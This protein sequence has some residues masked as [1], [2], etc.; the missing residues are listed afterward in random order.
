MIKLLKTALPHYCVVSIKKY[1]I[2]EIPINTAFLK[3]RFLKNHTKAP[4]ISSF[5]HP[6]I[7]YIWGLYRNFQPYFGIEPK[8]FIKK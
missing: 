2:F 7:L 1:K 3:K 6:Q 5:S 8:E 4:I